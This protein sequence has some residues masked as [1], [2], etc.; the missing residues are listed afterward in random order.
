MLKGRLLVGVAVGAFLNC[1]LAGC[2]IGHAGGDARLASM[3]GPGELRL[4]LPTRV[5]TSRDADTVDIYMTDLPE[6]VWIGGADVSDMAGTILH[7]HMFIRPKAGRTPI[8]DTASTATLRCMVLAKGEIGVYGGGGFFVDGA[9][10]GDKEFHGSVRNATLRL[11][12]ATAGFNDRL[13]VAAFSGSVSGR[14]DGETA[15]AME[16]AMR[17]LANETRAVE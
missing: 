13:G 14:L 10:V 5:Y 2:G 1:F 9:D 6:S 16:R 17:A 4:D 3:T 15:G 11:V 7:V 8:A 12:S